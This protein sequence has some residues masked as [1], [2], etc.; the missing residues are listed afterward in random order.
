M[1]EGE[2]GGVE[3]GQGQRKV[4]GRAWWSLAGG[5][6]SRGEGH[7]AWGSLAWGKAAEEVDTEG[8]RPQPGRSACKE[9]LHIVRT[10][11]FLYLCL[12]VSVPAAVCESE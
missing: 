9:S 7:R 1:V 12:S 5:A 6:G 11:L 4:E 3:G 10:C 8:R 2:R